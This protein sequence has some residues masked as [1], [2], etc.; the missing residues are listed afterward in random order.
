MGSV[1][2]AL[3][4]SKRTKAELLK[5]YPWIDW[6]KVAVLELTKKE[7]FDRFIKSRKEING[8]D[9]E[10]CERVDWHPVDWLPLKK[11]FVEELKKAGKEPR[12]KPM[13]IG[14]FNKWL[15]KL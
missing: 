7:I 1:T 4:V 2:I 13:T 8:K 6:S 14:E 12:G 10:F 15:N 9:A 11:E 3:S 5:R